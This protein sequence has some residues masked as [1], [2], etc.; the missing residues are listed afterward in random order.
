M[1]DAGRN[2]AVRRGGVLLLVWCALLVSGAAAEAARRFDI[3]AQ[4]LN[5]ALAQYSA[6]T[7][8]AVLFDS[9][10]VSGRRSTALAGHFSD[11]AALTQL[12]VGTGLEAHYSGAQGLT[13]RRHHAAAQPA[14]GAAGPH[15]VAAHRYATLVQHSLWQALCASALTRPGSYRAAVQL[16]IA[17]DGRVATS[18]LLASTG[19]AVRDAAL[20]EVLASLHIAL[21]PP[22]TMAQ[23]LTLLL[24]AAD[25]EGLDDSR[26]CPGVTDVEADHQGPVHPALRGT[27]QPPE[28][29]ARQ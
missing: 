10:L 28:L 11:S 1:S 9:A 22:P 18:R 29:P 13:L 14:A 17:A 23:P 5:E 26:A 19:H 27:A 20:R 21:A 6:L 3:A 16:H 2:L 24:R 8:M 15:T 4:P 12:L 25:T 7:G